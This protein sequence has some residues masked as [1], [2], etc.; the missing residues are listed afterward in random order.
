MD[1][2]SSFTFNFPYF[3]ERINVSLAFFHNDKHVFL[4]SKNK[5]I[6]NLASEKT[7][8]KKLCLW[9]YF[10]IFTWI[11]CIFLIKKLLEH[12]P[13]TQRVGGACAF[14]EARETLPSA[15]IYPSFVSV[16]AQSCPLPHGTTYVHISWLDC[17]WWSVVWDLSF[18]SVSWQHYCHLFVCCL[19]RSSNHVL[20]QTQALVMHDCNI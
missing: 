19:P 10:S 9:G 13:H 14:K 15:Q 16:D 6:T 7:K 8:K 5:Q 2:N 3:R 20:C 17:C 12:V 18:F 4:I 11:F 1:C